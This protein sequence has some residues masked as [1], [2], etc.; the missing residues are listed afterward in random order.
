MCSRIS[1]WI[2]LA[3]AAGSFLTSCGR[4]QTAVP[5][6]TA[7]VVP[8]QPA[9]YETNPFDQD[10]EAVQA[11][12]KLFHQFNCAGCHREGPGA[13]A[14]VL[15]DASWTHSYGSAYVFRSLIQGRPHGSPAFGGVLSED[16]AWKIVAYVGSLADSTAIEREARLE[17]R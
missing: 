7:S 5:Q 14:P 11:G 13:L 10:V 16:Q 1:G 8:L 2:L 6:R 17:P 4:T 9:V 3:A 15:S 12:R